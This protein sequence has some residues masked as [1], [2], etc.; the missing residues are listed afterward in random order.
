[1]I[2][3]D[4]QETVDNLVKE[5]TQLLE[6]NKQKHLSSGKATPVEI[7]ARLKEQDEEINKLK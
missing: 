6:E 2:I 3:K 7:N 4:L 5:K 1:M